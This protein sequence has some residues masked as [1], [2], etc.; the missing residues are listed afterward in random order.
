LRSTGG[1]KFLNLT[2]Q[3]FNI[4]EYLHLTASILA[5]N[6]LMIFEGSTLKIINYASYSLN[7]QVEF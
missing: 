4:E 3:L 5:V 6:I 1:L 2:K 7:I